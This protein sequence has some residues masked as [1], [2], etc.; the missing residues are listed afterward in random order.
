FL[1]GSEA[2]EKRLERKV[3]EGRK[4]Y[5]TR[6]MQGIVK[7]RLNDAIQDMKDNNITP[8]EFLKK[9]QSDYEYITPEMEMTIRDSMQDVLDKSEDLK[10]QD[11]DLDQQLAVLQVELDDTDEGSPE[12]MQVV[13]KMTPLKTQKNKIKAEVANIAGTMAMIGDLRNQTQDATDYS[14]KVD[15]AFK[16]GTVAR[17]EEAIY[18]SNFT[19]DNGTVMPAQAAKMINQLTKDSKEEMIA[20]PTQLDGVIAAFE[21]QKKLFSTEDFKDTLTDKDFAYFTDRYFRAFKQAYPAIDLKP[22]DYIQN[23]DAVLEA[24]KNLQAIIK[25]N[26]DSRQQRQQESYQMDSEVK[27]R[28]LGLTK[29]GSVEHAATVEFIENVIG[30]T[31]M[32][33][34][35]KEAVANGMEYP[36]WEVLM[37]KLKAVAST[38]QIRDLKQ[39]MEQRKDSFVDELVVLTGQEQKL[40]KDYMDNPLQVVL[41]IMANKNHLFDGNDMDNT[42]NSPAYRFK[43]TFSLSELVRAMGTD[44]VIPK[45]RKEQ[46]NKFIEIHKQLVGIESVLDMLDSEVVY[47]D[48]VASDSANLAADK[49]LPFLPTYQQLSAIR[50]IARFIKIDV[51]RKNLSAFCTLLGRAGSGKTTIVLSRVFRSLGIKAEEMLVS[52]TN[53]NAVETV[54]TALGTTGIIFEDLLKTDLKGKK[55]IILDEAAAISDAQFKALMTKVT[56]YNSKATDEDLIRVIFAGDPNQLT[57]SQLSVPTITRT[58]VMNGIDYSTIKKIPPLTIAYRSDV[59]ALNGF[60]DEFID[61]TKLVTGIY[62]TASDDL[63][64]LNEKTVGVFVDSRDKIADTARKLLK[65]S[66]GKISIA[67]IV[68]TET[69]KA[70]YQAMKLDAGIEILT[71]VE[72]QGRTIDKTLVDITRSKLGKISDLDFNR[73]M[74]TAITRAKRLAFVANTTGTFKQTVD[75]STA[76]NTDVRAKDISANAGWYVQHIRKEQG[77]VDELIKGKKTVVPPVVPSPTTPGTTVVT[78]PTEPTETITENEETGETFISKEGQPEDEKEAKKKDE[79][80]ADVEAP[81]AAE[82]SDHVAKF[83]E[84][85][86]KSDLENLK[87]NGKVKYVKVTYDQNKQDGILIL[88]QTKEGKYRKVGEVQHFGT[89]EADLPDWLKKAVAA[90]PNTNTIE[91]KNKDRSTQD[92]TEDKINDSVLAEGTLKRASRLKYLYKG[93]ISGKGVVDLV[94]GLWNENFKLDDKNPVTIT[95]R[96]FTHKELKDKKFN[97]FKF[98]HL[99]VGVPYLIIEGGG[100]NSIQYIEMEPV[101]IHS[102]TTGVKELEQFRGAMQRLEAAGIGILGE[103]NFNNAVRFFHQDFVPAGT[104]VVFNSHVTTIENIHKYLPTITQEQFEMLQQESLSIIP[105]YFGVSSAKAQL[106]MSS[107]STALEQYRNDAS[108]GTKFL[109]EPSEIKGKVKISWMR[110]GETKYSPY[111]KPHLVAGKGKAQYLIQDITARHPN[112]VMGG[113]IPLVRHIFKEPTVSSL[114][115]ETSF[116]EKRG[117]AAIKQEFKAQQ[118]K[119]FGYTEE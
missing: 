108:D 15:A 23:L 2:I 25:D 12:F 91:I 19:D 3:P 32:D 104:Q 86:S 114:M 11:K 64:N 65:D 80:P 94:L 97:L 102:T 62:G 82:P 17:M 83:P 31:G 103:K 9:V 22:S 84:N 58:S 28:G 59:S 44:S 27:F 63:Q 89:T 98:G 26:K 93:Y 101:N 50:A 51:E 14:A 48:L 85:L 46:I 95:A 74:Y 5:Y 68:D 56:D 53:P 87:P 37:Q 115:A 61:N 33:K 20:D 113:M 107:D 35:L 92:F 30:K 6:A 69:T 110:P 40:V 55:L 13:S 111:S 1:Q 96:I 73:I 72:S 34:I 100:L 99:K 76:E 67:I 77:I 29:D 42:P 70:E 16:G 116:K 118:M 54:G 7:N 43:K 39:K 10:Q 49:L 112:I 8:S 119:D 79:Q 4:M 105:A 36:Y 81:V 24:L 45:D 78:E 60:A 38:E 88:A 57:N 47:E 41:T 52:A 18:A 90:M 75:K 109:I 117:F 106:T 21:A 66:E 71:Y